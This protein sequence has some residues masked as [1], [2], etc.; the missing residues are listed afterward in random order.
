MLRFPALFC[1]L[2][3]SVFAQT[4][5]APIIRFTTS[6]GVID[7]Q[8]LPDSAPETVKNFLNYMRRGD[9]NSSVFHRSV[10]GFIL[11]GGGFRWQNRSFHTITSDPPVRNE[12]KLQ[13]VRGT[14]AMAKLDGDPNSATNQW[15]FNLADNTANLDIQ[16]GGF[17]V[18]GRV[19][20]AASLT[21]MDRI[22]SVRVPVPHPLNPPFD[23]M[24]LIN[25]TGG[26][27][28]DGNLILVNTVAE[29]AAPPAISAN[30]VISSA[31]FGAMPYAAPGSFIEIYGSNLAGTVSRGWGGSD[32]INGRAPTSLE[33]VSVSIGGFPA[34]VNF[35]SKGQVNVQVPGNLPSGRDVSVVVNVQ[36]Q[37]T[38]AYQLPL[39]SVAG[40][41]LAPTSFKVGERQY[42]AAL[43]SATNT[44]V[45]N[46]SIPDIAAAPARPGE[47]LIFYGVGFGSVTPEG[48]P[49]AGQVIA[50]LTALVNPVKFTIGSSDAAVS[51]AGIAPGFLGL[52]QF[53]VAVPAGLTTG[54]HPV[55][56]EQDGTRLP[57]ALFLPVA[58][59]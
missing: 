12:F 17:T 46:G 2:A 19:A 20:N 47:T 18:F 4:E 16:N 25:Y 59:N 44:F 57:Q 37:T 34:F 48:T 29:L 9:F 49:V 42:A 24:P 32:F 21:I 8:M 40:G 11:Q 26:Q 54:D 33:G 13:N 7:V 10:A 3:A 51:Y 1:A 15:F 39:R 45:S 35:V 56:V 31:G 50:G 30:G 53:N 41:I 22:A 43:H 5:P 6:L 27:L 28:Q 36:G 55:A 14:I 58:A 52:Y 23:A 38:G